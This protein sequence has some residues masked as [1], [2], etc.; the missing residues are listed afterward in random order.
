VHIAVIGSGISGLACAHYLSAE[1][2]VSVFEANKRLGG[3]TATMDVQVGTRRY[4]N[5]HGVYC[6]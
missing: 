2:T 1:H 3:H 6:F 5:R 4:R